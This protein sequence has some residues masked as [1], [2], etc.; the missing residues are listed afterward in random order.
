MATV[1]VNGVILSTAIP[2]DAQGDLSFN[3]DT[4]PADEGY[5]TVVASSILHSGVPFTLSL[6]E[7]YRPPVGG[8]IT[9]VV[10]SGIAMTEFLNLPLVRD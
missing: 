8:G 5:Y 6:S 1:S 4:G 2:V 10:P 7:P 3:L 9:L